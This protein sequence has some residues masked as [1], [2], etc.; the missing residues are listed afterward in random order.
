MN[1][2]PVR[3]VGMPVRLEYTVT[4]G[5]QYSRYLRALAQKK[6]IGVRCDE[7]Q[8][9]YVPPRGACPTCGVP[10]TNE[11]TGARRGD[12]HDLL[13]REHSVP[14]HAVRSAVRRGRRPPRRGEH[15]R[16]ST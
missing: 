4:P 14:Q 8:R 15:P 3:V 11:V 12:G 1:R 9:V 6:I 13:R 16:L 10:S 7:C 2:E 5:R